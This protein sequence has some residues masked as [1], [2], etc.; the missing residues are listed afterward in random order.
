MPPPRVESARYG[1]EG[2]WIDATRVVN[3]L[4][5]YGDGVPVSNQLAGDPLP[6]V[7][8][9]LRC[10]LDDGTTVDYVEGETAFWQPIEIANLLYHICPFARGRQTW[11]YDIA[12]LKQHAGWVNGKRI[13]S[14]VQ[15]EGCDDADMVLAEFGDFRIDKVIVRLNADVWEM[16]TFPAA[17]AEVASPA[18]N[19]AMFYAHAKGVSRQGDELKAA[20]I[21]TQA[22][23]VFLFGNREK[24]LEKLGRYAAVGSFKE[25]YGQWGTDWH[26]SGTFFAI[27]N[28]RLF[29]R[30]DWHPLHSHK[31]FIEFYPATVI[32]AHEAYNL[33]PVPAASNW[34]DYA[35]WGQAVPALRAAEQKWLSP[36]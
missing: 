12:L 13:V 6:G 1:V 22:M 36:A 9:R 25:A 4:L 18:A 28:D 5:A 31:Y 11:R 10:E 26:F 19:E 16:A 30:P 27:R 21:W 14:I 29:T 33:C 8:K 24:V 20:M 23:M 15:G 32:Q 17:I 34:V 7:P 35:R 3:A 2:A